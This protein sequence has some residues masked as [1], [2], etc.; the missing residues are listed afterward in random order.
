MY[1]ISC[2]LEILSPIPMVWLTRDHNADT[3]E[4]PRTDV[5]VCH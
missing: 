2:L 4:L 5:A 3:R 1:S